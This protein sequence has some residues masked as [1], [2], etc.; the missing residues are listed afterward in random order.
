MSEIQITHEA[1]ALLKL[2]YALYRSRREEGKGR[3]EA[4]Y[5]GS[6]EEIKQNYLNRMSSD[7]VAELC[8]ELAEHG[9]ITYSAGDDIAGEIYLTRRSLVHCEQVFQR[10]TKNLLDWISS[11]KGVLP[12]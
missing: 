5:I 9:F 12:F 10:N 1:E 8:F 4:S 2:L 3:I 7:D 11:I 6:S